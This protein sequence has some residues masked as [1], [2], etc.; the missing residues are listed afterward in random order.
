MIENSSYPRIALL[1]DSPTNAVTRSAAELNQRPRVPISTGLAGLLQQVAALRSDQPAVTTASGSVSYSCLLSNASA[2]AARL[3]RNPEFRRGSRVIV[4][5]PNSVEYLAAFFGVLIAGG[6]V[7]PVPA[8]TESNMLRDV[9]QRTVAVQIIASSRVMNARPDLRGL[10]AEAWNLGEPLLEAPIPEAEPAT[11]SE[12]DLAAIFFTAGSTGTP[13]GVM[14]THGNLISNAESIRQYLRIRP[15]DKPL[16]ILPFHHAFGNSV[17]QS[18]L[19]AGAQLILDG[20]TS[21]PQTIVEALK[22]HEC[23]SLSGVPDLFRLLL[24]RSPLGAVPLPRLRY[25]AVAGGALPHELALEVQR[26][27]APAEFFVMYGQSEATARLAFVPPGWLPEITDDC[28]GQAIPGVTLEVVDDEGR[29]LAPGSVGE[30]RA[31]GANIMPGYWRDPA[32]T[33]QR[34]RD[35]WLQTGDLATV[36]GAGRI[37]LK[38]RRNALVKIAG[39]RVHPADLENFVTRRFSVRQA[40]AVACEAEGLGTRFALFVQTPRSAESPTVSEMVAGCRAELPRHL[41]PEWIQ[42]LDDFPLNPAMKI[43]RPLLSQWAVAAI[44]RRRSQA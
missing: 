17:L 35:G 28:I 32:G 34:I 8:Q 15:D 40:V 21:F 4:L 38:G 10:E 16:C 7:V 42:I 29:V 19:L 31:R 24:D 9:V 39:F 1:S 5:L 14:L 22:R 12:N 6:V 41:V 37:Y 13:K 11:E 30:L 26:R 2:V 25:M 33:D 44:A 27:V 36:D 23:T 18:H 3:E 20:S 43:D